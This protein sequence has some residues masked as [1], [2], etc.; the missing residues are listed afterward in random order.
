MAAPAGAASAASAMPIVRP[1]ID[2]NMRSSAMRT[3]RWHQAATA[4]A[5]VSFACGPD[6][7]APEPAAEGALEAAFEVTAG[8]P[9]AGDPREVHL[10]NIK[11]LT[12]EG[13]NAEA[14]FSFDGRNLSFQ[15]TAAGGGCDQ[16]YTLDL[17]TGDTTRI[18]HGTGRTTCAYFYPAGDRV[19][20]ASTHGDDPTCPAKPD[21]SRGYVWPVYPTYEIF[22]ADL[23]GNIL[24]QLTDSPGYD[25]EATVS[26]KGDRIVFTSSRDDDLELYTMNLDGSDVRRITNRLGYDGGAFFSPDGSKIVWRA[27]YPETP[28]DQADYRALLADGLIRPTV[29]ELWVANAAGSD[30]RQITNFGKAS[31][32]P[33]FHP[34]GQKIIFS[35]NMD[36][37]EGRDFD[38]YMI[39]IDGAGL[40][41]LTFAAGFDGFPMFSPDGRW[42]AFGSNRNESHEGNTN[43]FVAE[44][45]ETPEAALTN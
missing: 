13:E 27:Q 21:F 25:A 45:V 10:R 34:S 39:G 19:L 12:T 9:L 33:F 23:S 26:P 40:E 4:A 44:W 38:I 1:I 11:Q 43:V 41:R 29:L 5:L 35:S 2:R 17:A 16:I 20:Y 14:Y 36:D 24:T 8:T 32:A 22:V 15:R 6:Q 30:A 31:F 3:F 42:L 18:S 37:P 7:P 28:A